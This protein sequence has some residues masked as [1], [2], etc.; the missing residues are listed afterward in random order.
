MRGLVCVTI[1]WPILWAAILL[2]GENPVTNGGFETLD[3]NGFPQDWCSYVPQDLIK[4]GNGVVDLSLDAHSGRHSVRLKLQATEGAL[5]LNRVGKP[6]DSEGPGKMLTQ[7]KGGIEFY[8]KAISADGGRLSLNVIPMKAD[9]IEGGGKRTTYVIPPEQIGDGKWHRW[10][11]KYDYTGSEEVRYIQVCPRIH[12]GSGEILFDD[13]AY[14]PQVGPMVLIAESGLREVRGAE[15]QKCVVSCTIENVGGTDARS[16]KCRLEGPP[17]L[18]LSPAGVQE[19]ARVASDGKETVAWV[20]EGARDKRGEMALTVECAGVE[21]ARKTIALT[22][23]VVVD[24]VTPERLILTTSSTLEIRCTVGNKGTANA[25]GA[26]LSLFPSAEL[27][28]RKGEAVE[29]TLS[30]PAGGAVE[31]RWRLEARGECRDAAALVKMTFEG[32][33]HEASAPRMVIIAP[34]LNEQCTMLGG[35]FIRISFPESSF[36]YGVVNIDVFDGQRWVRAGAIPRLGRQVWLNARGDRLERPI[37]SR[38]L[39]KGISNVVLRD[40][41]TDADRRTW[42]AETVFSNAAGKRSILVESRLKCDKEARLLCF[43]GP[44]VYAGEGSFGAAKSDALFAGLEWLVG[45]EVSSSTLDITSPDHVRY[46]PHPNKVTLPI[47]AVRKDRTLLAVLW[48]PKAPWTRQEVETGAEQLPDG[49]TKPIVSRGLDRPSPVFASP[50]RF[51]NTASH[52]MGLVVPTVPLW[53]EENTREAAVPFLLKSDSPLSIRMEIVGYGD[54]QD[55][56]APVDY[57]FEMNGAPDPMPFPRG[58]WEKEIAFSMSAYLDTLWIPAQKKWWSSICPNPLIQKATLPPDFCMDLYMG[59]QSVSDKALRRSCLTRFNEVLPLLGK[60]VGLNLSYHVGHVEEMT[61]NAASGTLGL[62]QSQGPE[63]EWRYN[64]ERIGTGVFEGLDY[65]RLGPHNAVEVGTCAANA[66]RLLAFARMTGDE[67]ALTAGLKA[68][69]FMRRFQVPR[70]AQVWEIPVHT[71]DLLASAIASRAYLEA[72]RITGQKEHLDESVRWA[73]T[74]LPFLYVWNTEEFPFMRYASIPVY[75]ATWFRGSWFG[76]PVQWNG[77]EY[78]DALFDL[79]EHDQSFPW[80]KIAEGITISALYQQS[81]DKEK[82]YALWPDSISAIDAKKSAWVFAPHRILSCIA[83]VLGSPYSPATA[84]LQAEGGRL[85]ITSPARIL[86]PVLDAGKLAFRMDLAAGSGYYTSIAVLERPT[87]VLMDKTEIPY[88]PKLEESD[89]AAWRYTPS[90]GMVVIKSVRGGSTG[91]EIGG[92]KPK[93]LSLLPEAKK[94]VSFLFDS[95]GD[96][97]GWRP[98]H[99]VTDMEASGGALHMK[100]SGGDPYIVRE[101]LDVK[102]PPAVLIVRMRTSKGGG[103]QVFWRTSDSPAWGQ[104]KQVGFTVVGDGQAHDYAL[105]M[106]SHDQWKGKHITALR[107]DPLSGPGI[108]GAEVAVD[109]ITPK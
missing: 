18:K 37:Y 63:G 25:L 32:C 109:F 10:V 23:C 55:C 74:G 8:Y 60:N 41:F 17:D 15:G 49:T 42:T 45:D 72:Y 71:P 12:Q 81:T 40:S 84:I 26:R 44:M 88:A 108:E 107:L 4:G 54:A 24:S 31:T 70:A 39:E 94:E 3:A 93:R 58:S 75:G 78:A 16:V 90:L 20:V 66:E 51:E 30:V 59:A 102:A 89:A 13:I 53:L 83:K 91:I 29:R 76:R 64:A 6:K 77:L 96:M 2:A 47:M 28:L 69:Q 98:A 35:E 14:V 36:G 97:E 103:G 65:R 48:D 22:P 101:H 80:H 11:Q 68:L 1:A 104:D 33:V 50:N 79:S 27:R 34:Y 95:A 19:L 99:D 62:I 61:E 105:D 86:E 82:N 38:T 100:I 21:P 57:W 67:A 92:I 87:N 56:L 5:G 43:E 73:R 85:H 9:G 106:A 52:L 46:V 7:R